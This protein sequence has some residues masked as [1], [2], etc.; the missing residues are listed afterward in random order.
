MRDAV[1]ELVAA[2]HQ[3]RAGGRARRADM[4]WREEQALLFERIH[5]LITNK[6]IAES[7]VVAVADLV[8]HHENDV[9]FC[10]AEGGGDRGE[11]QDGEREERSVREY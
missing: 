4:E 3:R 1:F 8:G 7:S 5:G 6:R 9:G 11:Q 10:S 2:A